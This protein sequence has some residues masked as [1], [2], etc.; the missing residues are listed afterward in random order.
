MEYDGVLNV[1]TQAVRVDEV[2]S[3]TGQDAT[4]HPALNEAG[5]GGPQ[6][7]SMYLFLKRYVAPAPVKRYTMVKAIVK[8]NSMTATVRLAHEGHGNATGPT[9]HPGRR[10]CRGPLTCLCPRLVHII[11]LV[12][13]DVSLRNGCGR[14]LELNMEHCRNM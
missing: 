2:E 7:R 1:Q 5:S 11:Q 10:P 4:V 3:L 13:D 12:R 6:R 9:T 8:S 14:R